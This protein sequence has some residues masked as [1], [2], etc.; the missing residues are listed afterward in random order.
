[1]NVSTASGETFCHGFPEDTYWN[2][3][4]RKVHRS[5]MHASKLDTRRV[6][7]SYERLVCQDLM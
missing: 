7:S 3:G 5:G 4:L 2:A 6:E 1:M